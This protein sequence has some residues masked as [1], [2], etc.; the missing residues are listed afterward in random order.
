MNPFE[1]EK[2]I[3]RYRES[4]LKLAKSDIARKKSWLQDSTIRI[5]HAYLVYIEY[6]MKEALI[7]NKLADFLVESYSMIITLPKNWTGQ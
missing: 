5:K 7:T 4:I 2:I 6:I 1:A 3:N